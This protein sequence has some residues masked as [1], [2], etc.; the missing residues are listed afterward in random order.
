MAQIKEDDPYQLN[1]SIRSPPRI[2]TYPKT[3]PLHGTS[4]NSNKNELFY[5]DAAL[6][7][8]NFGLNF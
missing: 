3:M 8:G 4:I 7:F 1:L 2:I 5:C 6:N